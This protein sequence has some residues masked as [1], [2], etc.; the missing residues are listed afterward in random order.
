[1]NLFSNII[2]ALIIVNIVV[3][4]FVSLLWRN[5]NT[6][7][8]KFLMARSF[9]FRDLP[10]YIEKSWIKPYLAISYSCLILFILFIVSLFIW[11][12]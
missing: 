4:V 5:K 8:A 3:L 1:M 12:I 7:F 10:K 2:L 11:E 6:N 9:I